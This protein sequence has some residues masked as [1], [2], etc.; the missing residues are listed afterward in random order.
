MYLSRLLAYIFK[1]D[2]FIA[3][4]KLLT[5]RTIVLYCTSFDSMAP[6]KDVLIVGA[7]PAGLMLGLLLS[8]AKIPVRILERD[9][10]ATLETRA[11][12]YNASSQ[13]E[14]KRA[15][16]YE[17]VMTQAMIMKSVGFRDLS[18]K[19]LFGL[20]GG[21]GHI[22][23]PQAELTAIIERHLREQKNAEI[24]WGH[25]VVGLGQ[26]D[27]NA[28]VDVESPGGRTRL[29]AAYVVGCDG[30]SS[31]VRRN[32]LG[33]EAMLGFTWDK[34]LVA[35]DVRLTQRCSQASTIPS[36]ERIDLTGTTDSD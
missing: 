36:L 30:G 2:H 19:R 14:F 33:K 10:S 4:A 17:E 32:L 24:L 22:V 13:A 9:T 1:K 35:A 29:Q 27:A 8:R 18:G 15:G 12:L 16:I 20:P 7:G 26:D 34:Q 11:L 25:A 3:Q 6:I 21:P 23:L 28:W 31:A 5:H